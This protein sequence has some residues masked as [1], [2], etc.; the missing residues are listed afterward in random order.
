MHKDKL[1]DAGLLKPFKELSIGAEIFNI[2][3]VR[4]S[5]TN[6]YV[7][8]VYTKTQFAVPNFLSPRVY[9]IRLTAKF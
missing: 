2:F 8:D 9:N 4:N 5:I 6:T 3:D 1:K 7:R